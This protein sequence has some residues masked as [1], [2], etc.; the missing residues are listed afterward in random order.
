MDTPVE[1]CFTEL[2]IQIIE[3][4]L[5]Q[6]QRDIESENNIRKLRRLANELLSK[7]E[8][9]KTRLQ[10]MLPPQSNDDIN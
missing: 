1:L 9:L 10:R 4:T 2:L 5:P 8:L 7:I 3:A 6:M